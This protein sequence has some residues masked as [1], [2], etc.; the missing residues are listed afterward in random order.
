MK[1]LNRYGAEVAVKYGVSGMTDITGFGLAGH[2]MKMAEA[3]G[4]S[5]RI[6]SSQ[7]PLLPG[8]YEVFE[9]GSI[10]GATF[11]NLEFT[12]QNAH[13]TRGVDY[14]MKML[15]HDAQTSGG[16]LMSVN[17][18]HAGALMEVL[19]RIDPEHPAVEIGEVLKQSPRRLYFE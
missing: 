7:V 11:R 8:A 1:H 14:N 2:A 13:C 17:P 10:P 5:F 16:L 9:K 18:D 6:R 15:F 3:S 12:G 4:V 19:K